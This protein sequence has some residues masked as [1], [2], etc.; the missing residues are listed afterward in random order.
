MDTW[1]CA[2]LETGWSLG[3]HQCDC[4]SFM[5]FGWEL[6]WEA[7]TCCWELLQI[8]DIYK[9]VYFQGKER[10]KRKRFH[11]LLCMVFPG[12]RGIFMYHWNFFSGI[13][14]RV[15]KYQY[16]C[17]SS[18]AL[19]VNFLSS[20]FL[21]RII[22]REVKL[23]ALIHLCSFLL[24]H[25][26]FCFFSDLLQKCYFLAWKFLDVFLLCSHHATDFVL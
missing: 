2:V 21:C 3:P 9:G 4:S 26:D 18:F 12:T 17:P 1:L 25:T 8:W 23:F 20:L 6:H 22:F 11:V 7:V 13:H 19:T 10:R 5:I 16:W 15:R 24:K 14:I